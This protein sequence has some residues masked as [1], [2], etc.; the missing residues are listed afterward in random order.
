MK[1]LAC[2]WFVFAIG[3]SQAGDRAERNLQDDAKAKAAKAQVNLLSKA[4]DVFALKNKGEY[5]AKLE[6]LLT[7]K[8]AI[9]ESKAALIDPWKKP[10]MYDA[11]G[12]KNSGV[13]PDIWTV[14][15]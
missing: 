5:P 1:R 14:T 12:P 11:S 8:P 3:F 13:R 4:V 6:D 2:W 10:Y 15:P 7:T 9:L